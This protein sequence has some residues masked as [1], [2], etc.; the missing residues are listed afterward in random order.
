MKKLLSGSYYIVLLLGVLFVVGSFLFAKNETHF[1]KGEIAGHQQ[2]TPQSITQVDEMTKE[3][4][5]SGEQ[6]TGKNIC[7]AFYSIHL[8]I[9]VYEDGELIYDLK[10]VPGIFGTTPGSVWNFLEIEPGCGQVIV[11]THAAY[12]RVGGETLSFYIGEAV[13]EVLYLIRNSAIGACVCLLELAIGIFLIMY[14]IIGNKGIRIENYVLYFGL[15]AVLMGAWSLNE[16]V[17]MAL[18]VK[19]TVVLI[20]G[21]F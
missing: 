8:G 14:F 9:E 20:L 6:F 21:I 16:T 1:R 13:D 7:L 10:P 19:N 2:I 18:L 11:R 12:R 4:I 17:L 3:Y 15:F 5:F